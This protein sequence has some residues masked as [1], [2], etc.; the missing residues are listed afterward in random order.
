M[1]IFIYIYAPDGLIPEIFSVDIILLII[2][3][4]SMKIC[5]KNKESADAKL[6]TDGH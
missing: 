2:T 6:Q 5:I 4:R 3:L 1:N